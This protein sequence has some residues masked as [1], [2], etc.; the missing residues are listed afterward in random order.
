[1]KTAG[2]D[3]HGVIY[4]TV[5]LLCVAAPVPDLS[6]VLCSTLKRVSAPAQSVNVVGSLARACKAT[7][8]SIPGIHPAA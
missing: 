8:K 2:D 7:K 5:Q 4:R 3:A 1:M 6:G